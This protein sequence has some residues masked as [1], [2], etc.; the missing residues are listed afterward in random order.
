MR[1]PSHRRAVSSQ[2]VL[3][4]QCIAEKDDLPT[5][6]HRTDRP[7]SIGRLLILTCGTG[8][9]QMFWSTVMANLP[10]FL[11]D[12]GISKS[13]VSII[14]VSGPLSGCVVAPIAGIVSDRLRSRWGRRRP[15]ILIGAVITAIALLMLAWQRVLLR[16]IACS[17]G[18]CGDNELPVRHLIQAGA[19]LWTIIMTVSVQP[20]QSGVRS[21]MIEQAPAQEQNRVSA[22]ASRVAGLTGI[23][24]LWASSLNLPTLL[25]LEQVA[26]QFQILAF[27]NS[28]VLAT[29]SILICTCIQEPDTRLSILPATNTD[30][31]ISVLLLQFRESLRS[32]PERIKSICLVQFCAWFAWFSLLYGTTTYI[33]ELQKPQRARANVNPGDGAQA[34]SFAS[35]CFAVIGLA[36]SLV[37]P[38]TLSWRL[39]VQK[40]AHSN[41]Q[42]IVD[43]ESNL[44]HQCLTWSLGWIA[45]LLLAAP[46]M[47]SQLSGTVLVALCGVSWAVSQWVP[48]AI[49]GQDVKIDRP[50]AEQDEDKTEGL[51]K[52]GTTVGV[53][54]IAVSLPQILAGL[55][56]SVVYGVAES[57]GSSAPTS[58]I[59]AL[60]GCAALGAV[61]L[62]KRLL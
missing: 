23:V 16:A 30:S 13:F 1:P 40:K 32:L 19:I 10:L 58:W 3:E 6:L 12:L 42:G 44:L 26:T 34:G 55:T 17:S 2:C 52:A 56:N 9:L 15:F 20:L 38:M 29:T 37:L 28:M 45:F 39:N 31:G 7:L 22:W 5:P 14:L 25:H 11:H 33:Q 47:G 43:Q 60:G 48:F 21:L 41:P 36:A 62:A 53:Y 61:G 24:S 54:G 27:L 57:M 18:S 4:T 50:A 49:I 46:M 59:L 51:S 8:G 35:M